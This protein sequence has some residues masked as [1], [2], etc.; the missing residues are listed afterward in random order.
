MRTHRLILFIAVAAL[1][2]GLLAGQAQNCDLFNG[3]P[4]ALTS[5][6][7]GILPAPI[8]LGLMA[9]SL[10]QLATFIARPRF[11]LIPIYHPPRPV[12]AR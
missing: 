9:L 12:R 3:G 7:A 6:V 4:H 2:G 8:V 1:A 11:V 5:C 10:V